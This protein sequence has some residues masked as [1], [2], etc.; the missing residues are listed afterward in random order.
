MEFTEIDR[1]RSEQIEELLIAWHRWQ[2]SYQ[3]A[4]G[5][6]R[7]SP[8]CREFEIPEAKLTDK[9]RAELADAKIWKRNSETVEVLVEALS[10]QQRAAIQTTMRNK[11]AGAEVF[12][13]PRFAPAEIHYL[14]QSAKESLFPHFVARGLIKI[15]VEAA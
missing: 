13:N 5:A 7:C 6:Q 11:R 9:E 1:A 14:Y 4:L 8:S 15:D 10:W 12:K 2:D 3:P